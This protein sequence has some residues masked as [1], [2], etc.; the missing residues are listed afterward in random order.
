[1]TSTFHSLVIVTFVICVLPIVDSSTSSTTSGMFNHTRLTQDDCHANL[2]RAKSQREY[3]RKL[4]LSEP[5]PYLR[6]IHTQLQDMETQVEKYTKCIKRTEKWYMAALSVFKTIY[7]VEIVYFLRLRLFHRR[8]AYLDKAVD[9]SASPET[10]AA[11][12]PSIQKLEIQIDRY[13]NKLA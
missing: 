11:M 2:T 3:L 12:K 1:M 10:L 8:R 13:E 6:Q 4:F 7:Y 9:E 5:R